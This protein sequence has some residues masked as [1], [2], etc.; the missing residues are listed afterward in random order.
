MHNKVLVA[1][2]NSP[3][4]GHSGFPVTYQKV[5]Q[6]FVWPGLKKYVQQFVQTCSV[7][8][9]AKPDHSPY[10]GLLQPLPVP[11]GA[12]QNISMD[13][14][15]GLPLSRGRNCV[16]VIVDKFSKFSH[17]IP[18]KHQFTAA[19][20]AQVFMQEVYRL[21][22]LPLAIVSDRNRIFTSQFWKT[23]FQLAGVSLNMSSAYHPQSDGQTERVNQCMETYL[24]CFVGA[25]PHKWVQWIYLAEYWY[26]VS[27]HSVV[28]MSPFQLLYGYQPWHFGVDLQ[29]AC[30]VV[31]LQEWLSEKRV[32]TQLVQQHL[33]RAQL[34]MKGQADKKRSERSFVV[35][36]RVFLKLQPYVQS[37]LAPRANQKLAFQFVVTLNQGYPLLQ[38]EGAESMRLPLATW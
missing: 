20:V 3:L 9:Q 10:P 5:K 1:L 38:C 32:M 27:W 8:Q 19:S 14:V 11:A 35:G 24:R 4:G 21:H 29:D 16:M 7:C 12:W 30:P 28:S 13:F 33:A 15:E 37:S 2:H 25:C 17:F 23:L 31:S 6:L 36:D 26:N 22:G 18:L 34:R